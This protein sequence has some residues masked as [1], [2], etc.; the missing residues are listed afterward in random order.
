MKSV[1]FPSVSHMF[2]AW[3]RRKAGA[4]IRCDSDVRFAVWL[5]VLWL[6][7]YNVRF[8]ELLAHAMW[9]PTLSSALFFVSIATVLVTAHSLLMLLVPQRLLRPVATVLFI[10]AAASAYFASS[11]GA[12]MNRDMMRNVFETDAAEVSGLLNAD[13][14]THLLVLGVLPGLLV[15]RV[16][17]R[18]RTWTQQLRE[19]G[20][21]LAAALALSI[22]GVF[23]TSAHYAVFLREYKSIRYTIMPA[24][25]TVSS[26]A[27]LTGSAKH[28]RGPMIQAGGPVTRTRA[29]N[30]RPLV[31]FLVV[32]E[33]ARAANFQL[34]GYVRATNP[35]LSTIDGLNYFSHATSCGTATAL[36]V[37]CMFSHLSREQFDIDEAGHYT[38][39]LD[40]FRDAGFDVEWRD[41]NAGCKGVCA[42]VRQVNYSD[43]SDAALCPNGY[44]FDEVMLTDLDARLHDLDRDTLIVFHQIGSHGPAYAERYP[45]QFERFRP[46]CRTNE[47]QHC[48]AQ[49]VVNAYDN[50]IVYTDHVLAQQI[51]ALRAADD[52]ID[53][54]LIYLSDHGESLGEQG[55]YL[56]GL[57]YRFA[58]RQQK[59]VPFLIWTSSGYALRAGLDRNCLQRRT[60]Q[61]ASQDN[62]YHTAM[63]AGELRNGVYDTRL[64]VMAGCRT[65]PR[66]RKGA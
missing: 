40:T 48:T 30:S 50:S 65:A 22:A 59:E 31:I 63:G 29:V 47:L 62:L 34:G 4:R 39:L 43:R 21:F 27:L 6:A 11:Y 64:D 3:I 18:K 26:L 5:A 32:G 13:F 16:V 57:P 20:L 12:L 36:S 58:P 23:A 60:Q 33:T 51:A 46:A 2:Y 37:P 14:L 1:E 42:R 15:W 55:V 8:W 53:S 56:H 54:V 41:N 49:E 44:C 25:P 66:A 28:R 61:P 10:V 24:A 45:A 19:R 38:N 9:H 52:R 17:L 7:F 35:E